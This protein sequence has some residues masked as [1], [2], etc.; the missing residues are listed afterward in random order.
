VCR[1]TTGRSGS[2]LLDR[3]INLGNWWIFL[4][5]DRAVEEYLMLKS[6]HLD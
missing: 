1:F 3:W 5:Y 4:E 6:M 2:H